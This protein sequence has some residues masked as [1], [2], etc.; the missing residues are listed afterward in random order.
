VVLQVESCDT[1]ARN[2]LSPQHSLRAHL[3]KFTGSILHIQRSITL[4]IKYTIHLHYRCPPYSIRVGIRVH[5]AV[6]NLVV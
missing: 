3:F 5:T 4:Q 6:P 1:F 2:L